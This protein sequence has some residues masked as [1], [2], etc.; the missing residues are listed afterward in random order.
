MVPS[1]LTTQLHKSHELSIYRLDISV[2]QTNSCSHAP[3]NFLKFL[4]QV[5]VVSG[6]EFLKMAVF[7]VSS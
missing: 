2:V 1:N 4:T 6:Y 7:G 5:P 3:Y